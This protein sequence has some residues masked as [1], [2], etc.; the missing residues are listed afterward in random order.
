MGRLFNNAFF[1]VVQILVTAICTFAL[2][3]VVAR[4]FGF[5]Y[6]G[7]WSL[8]F[9]LTGT[10]RLAEMGFSGAILR[11]TG[12]YSSEKNYLH[13]AKLCGTGVITVS[14]VLLLVFILVYPFHG[15]VLTWLVGDKMAANAIILFPYAIATLW[16]TSVSN[17]FLSAIEGFLNYRSSA[18]VRIVAA[19]SQLLVFFSVV[20][21]VGFPAVGIALA[22]GAVV[23]LGLGHL[24]FSRY[25][26]QKE[27]RISLRWNGA[28]FKE[29]VGYGTHLQ[30]NSL[31]SAGGEP[32]VKFFLSRFGGLEIVGIYEM[33]SKLVLQFRSV[34]VA[35]SQ[36]IVP[37]I[38][39]IFRNGKIDLPLFYRRAFRAI[40]IVGTP[41]FL[42]VYGI[43]P[44]FAR[45]WAEGA[46]AE[47]VLFASIL[48][49]AWFMNF[50]SMPAY[51]AYQ[52]VGK[53]KANT[54]SHLAMGVGN[55]VLAPVAGMLFGGIGVVVVWSFLVAICS[56]IV[57]V[58]FHSE[59]QVRDI[60]VTED[61][62][63]LVLAG[64]SVGVIL[65]FYHIGSLSGHLFLSVLAS[66]VVIIGYGLMTLFYHSVGRELRHVVVA[67]LM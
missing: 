31:L 65:I 43:I 22:S 7:V 13:V 21:I 28:A 39:G 35:A 9:A 62:V 29:L 1:N 37:T 19:I 15:V 30:L 52:G 42:I 58:L 48:T 63:L 16:C 3:R 54:Y 6:L 55:L 2:Y 56:N 26:I 25:M 10:A 59:Y 40:I 24:V 49:T 51:F 47:F 4:D 38:S 33:A 50:V 5:E 12:K 18:S 64:V 14:S 36:T 46:E 60:M 32:L 57:T 45:F 67:K 27:G 61:K 44:V 53:L 8:V 11:F 34:T 66:T 41:G 23:K 20:K 17:I